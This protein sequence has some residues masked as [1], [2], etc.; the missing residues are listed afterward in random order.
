LSEEIVRAVI[1]TQVFLRAAI[2][3]RSLPAKLIFDLRDQYQLI[4]SEELIAEVQ[5]IL[6]RPKIRAKFPHMSDKI[7]ERV[8]EPLASAEIIELGEIAEISR[9][10]KDD[11]FLAC[12]K[13]S[14]AGYLVSE[15]K[16]LFVLNPYKIFRL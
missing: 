15:D 9:D 8:I 14:R 4:A 11:M 12:A 1:D 3:L 6:Y 16:D 13:I 10:P 7:A 2:N 5:D